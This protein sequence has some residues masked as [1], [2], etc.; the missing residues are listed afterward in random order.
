ML[1][2]L[3]RAPSGLKASRR[4]LA[5]LVDA[6]RL[7]DKQ[8][9]THG[10]LLWIGPILGMLNRELNEYENLVSRGEN[11]RIAARGVP[12]LISMLATQIKHVEGDLIADSGL[13]RPRKLPLEPLNGPLEKLRTVSRRLRG[14]ETDF[15]R[16]LNELIRK[17]GVTPYAISRVHDEDPSYIYKLMKGERIKPSRETVTRI[18]LALMECSH[19]ISKKDAD[20]LMRSAGYPPLKR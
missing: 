16:V 7:L 6:V 8:R 9:N 10:I 14:P 13:I 18:A 3:K 1:K 5:E 11:I 2:F 17:S 20:R 19:K 4:A 12:S 15:Q